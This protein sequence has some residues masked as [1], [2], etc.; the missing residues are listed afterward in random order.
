MC[1][2]LFKHVGQFREH[3]ANHVKSIVDSMHQIHTEDSEVPRQH[4]PLS[5]AEL[6][7]EQKVLI[8]ESDDILYQTGKGKREILQGLKDQAG[9]R[10]SDVHQVDQNE[11]STLV[12]E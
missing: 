2:R 11:D 8:D 5:Y 4:I 1:E 10:S 12:N 7:D 6:S 3:A 9:G